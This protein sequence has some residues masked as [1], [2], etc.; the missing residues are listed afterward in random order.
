MKLVR[1]V[2]KDE[3]KYILEVSDEIIYNNQTF[4][5]KDILKNSTTRY[6]IIEDKEGQ[7]FVVDDKAVQ[8]IMK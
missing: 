6:I 2:I 7:I 3:D 4:L 8:S 1:D 5:V